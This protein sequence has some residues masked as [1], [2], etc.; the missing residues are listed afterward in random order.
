MHSCSMIVYELP[1]GVDLLGTRLGVFRN[2]LFVC[3]LV[4]R[5]INLQQFLCLK[6]S[7]LFTVTNGLFSVLMYSNFF[8]TL[9]P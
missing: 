9:Y 4:P 7:D 5:M 2:G 1:V 8:V 6:V 3:L